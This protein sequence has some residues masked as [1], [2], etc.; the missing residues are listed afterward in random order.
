MLDKEKLKKIAKLNNL[1]PWQQEKQYIQSLI[2]TIL[3]EE[4]LIFKGGT[5]LWFFQ[6]LNR[7]SEDL[8][9]TVY[10]KLP[11][12]LSKKVSESLE[13]F[14]VENSIKIIHDD[15]KSLSF[16]ISAKGPL[17]TSEKDLCFVYVE[18]SKREKILKKPK[19]Y[20]LEFPE[21]SSPIKFIL[22]MNI[23]EVVS[24]KVRAVMTRKKK[25]DIYD[26]WYLIKNK[27]IKF[28][29]DLINEKLKYYKEEFSE[30]AFISEIK[31]QEKN[32]K[33]EL[34]P[35]VFSEVPSFKECLKIIEKWID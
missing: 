25:R 19:T 32:F 5:Y 1:K 30:K 22:G 34:T 24:E 15:E 20:K 28:N 4:S 7:F 35:L 26:L 2:L 21:Y 33:K 6:G 9:F 23:E 13:L 8:D 10:E 14:G 12:N 16:R 31:K 11:P 18:I 27:K 3:S 29:K 17:N